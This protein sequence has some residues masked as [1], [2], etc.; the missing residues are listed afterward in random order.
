MAGYFPI[1]NGVD[2]SKLK[3]SE[4][5]KYSISKPYVSQYIID[6]IKEYYS[7]LKNMTITDTTANNGGDTI[8]F[9][10]NFKSVNA[11]EISPAEFKI[12]EN[13]VNQ[14][15]LKNVKLYNESFLTFLKTSVQDIIYIDAP[16]GG[17]ECVNN[18]FTNLYVDGINIIGVIKNIYEKKNFKL[19]ILKVPKNYNF[20]SL[21]KWYD[22]RYDV[23][24]MKSMNIIVIQ[25][26]I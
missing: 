17:P 19:L 7:D 11:V 13:N 25:K 22:M 20:V 12:L 1:I 16:W 10:M 3:V 14:Y 5:G 18:L 24:S 8:R 21:F 9:A 23:H 6:I 4:T 15:K 26:K 2:S